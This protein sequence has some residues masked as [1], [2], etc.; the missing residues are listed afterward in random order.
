MYAADMTLLCF[1]RQ[2]YFN[3]DL[4]TE[5]SREIEKR[6]TTTEQRDLK[7]PL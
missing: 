2:F 4:E 7:S 5:Q 6:E 3:I 1:P